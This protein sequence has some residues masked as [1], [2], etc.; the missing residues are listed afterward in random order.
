M[1][2]KII[3]EALVYDDRIRVM[4]AELEL[5]AIDGK[6]LHFDR[7]RVQRED[8]AAV[9]LFDRERDCFIFISQFRY[10]VAYH[11]EKVLM[12]LVSGE[13]ANGIGCRKS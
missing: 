2:P 10:P 5:L 11:Q 3:K 9:I 7:S 12:E 6:T 13:G 1:N 4:K 8:A